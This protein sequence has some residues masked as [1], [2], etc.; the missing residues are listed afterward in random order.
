MDKQQ[1]ETILTLLIADKISGNHKNHYWFPYRDF[2]DP[3][4][5]FTAFSCEQLDE[6]QEY[7]AVIENLLETDKSA[8]IFVEVYGLEENHK[9]QFVYADTLIIFSNLS[10][11]EVKQIFHEPEDI[12]PSDIGEMTDFSQPVFIIGDNGV[13]IPGAGLP[14]RDQSVYYCWWD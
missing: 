2:L 5:D 3:A 11:D 9:E 13:L 1:K 12:F 14:D 7:I 6:K 4:D 10:L 8:E